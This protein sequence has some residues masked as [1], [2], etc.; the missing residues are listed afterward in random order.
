MLSLLYQP[1][2]TVGRCIA[3]KEVCFAKPCCSIS[4]CKSRRRWKSELV[5]TIE[6]HQHMLFTSISMRRMLGG[7][8]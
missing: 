7:A 3:S 1:E 5:Q 4:M 2:A 6:V 8:L